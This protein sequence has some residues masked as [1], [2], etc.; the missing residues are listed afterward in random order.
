M[1]IY[2]AIFEDRE[3]GVEIKKAFSDEFKA[4]DYI[5]ELDQGTPYRAGHFD[6]IEMEV[7]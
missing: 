6:V 5:W 7:E 2:I 4:W 1:K 3:T